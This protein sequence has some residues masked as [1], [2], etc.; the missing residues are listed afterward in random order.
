[1]HHRPHPPMRDERNIPSNSTFIN[2]VSILL[3]ISRN[4]VTHG[5]YRTRHA[6]E[7]HEAHHPQDECLPRIHCAIATNSRIEKFV[8]DPFQRLS[9]CFQAMKESTIHA[10]EIMMSLV[11]YR[12]LAQYRQQAL[13]CLVLSQMA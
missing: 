4:G 1:M 11:Q 9:L 12:P 10:A 5:S 13:N 8:L 2:Q 3:A 7:A 6:T